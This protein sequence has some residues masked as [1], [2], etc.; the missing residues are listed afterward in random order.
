MLFNDWLAQICTTESPDDSIIAFNFGLFETENGYMVY[1]VG[2]STY[3]EEDE[4]WATEEDF[5]PSIKYFELPPEEF[6]HLRFDVV[7]Q[8]VKA[9]IEAFMQTDIFKQSFL[10][11]AVAITIGFDDGNLELIK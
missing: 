4:D 3:D 6:R 2:S 1:L 7:Q 10:F 9:K 5:V 8:K 11:R